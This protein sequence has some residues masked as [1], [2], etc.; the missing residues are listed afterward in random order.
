MIVLPLV[1][2]HNS[3]HQKYTKV[4]SDRHSRCLLTFVCSCNCQCRLSWSLLCLCM[5]SYLQFRHSWHAANQQD[6][7]WS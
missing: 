6:S 1:R 5:C 7:Q 4:K 3:E 2:I